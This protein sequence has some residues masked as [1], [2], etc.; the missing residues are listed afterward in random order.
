MDNERDNMSNEGAGSE[1]AGSE[2]GLSHMDNRGTTD[3]AAVSEQ[4]VCPVDSP[5]ETAGELSQEES[6]DFQSDPWIQA[7]ERPVEPEEW[8]QE[9]A[10]SRVSR[11]IRPAPP[12]SL[13]KCQTENQARQQAR[14]QTQ[15]QTQAQTQYQ[16]PYPTPYPTQ[17]QAQYPA[18]YQKPRKG[19]DGMANASL[20]M[21][22]LSIISCFACCFW[23]AIPLGIIGILFAVISK[24]DGAFNENAKPG[25]II[26]IIVIAVEIIMI[27]LAL[28]LNTPS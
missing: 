27:I 17:Y 9:Y 11:N 15:H 19:V 3:G 28:I 16:A 1:E 14:H 8:S 21:G 6:P 4:P 23:I 18:Q 10:E 5:W 25:F 20:V 26:C 12:V 7:G 2:E 24:A 22:I 13:S